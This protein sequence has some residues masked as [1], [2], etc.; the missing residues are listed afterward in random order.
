MN[1]LD[2]LFASTQRMEALH[3]TTTSRQLQPWVY[4]FF[5]GT[6][7][8]DRAFRGGVY[9]GTAAGRLS[10]QASTRGQS[11]HRGGH[12]SQFLLGGYP[13]V[14]SRL[15][16]D[17]LLDLVV[18]VLWCVTLYD[19][20]KFTHKLVMLLKLIYMKWMYLWS[21]LRIPFPSLEP[22]RKFSWPGLRSFFCSSPWSTRRISVWWKLR[23]DKVVRPA[24]A[25]WRCRWRRGCSVCPSPPLL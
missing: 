15:L 6:W 12:G 22:S 17:H 2:E 19:G 20:W 25:W 24:I 9:N 23:L 5:W 16:I 1:K 4:L 8:G 3:I 13:D 7:D 11:P 10:V 18:D 14:R 21:T